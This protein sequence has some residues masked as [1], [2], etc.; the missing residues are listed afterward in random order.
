MNGVWAGVELGT[1]GN[2]LMMIPVAKS[3]ELALKWLIVDHFATSARPHLP[4]PHRPH[5]SHL[6]L[7]AL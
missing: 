2:L 1:E 3:C 6:C 4:R 5:L 7:P